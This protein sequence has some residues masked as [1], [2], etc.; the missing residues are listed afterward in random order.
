[1]V[2]EREVVAGDHVDTGVLLELPVVSTEV[3]AD[4]L[5]LLGSDLAAPVALG[6]LLQ[7]TLGANTGKT[8]DSRH[9]H[10]C[11]SSDDS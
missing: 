3:L 9:H 1:V 7:L 5:E 10:Y 4:L 6:G 2:V 11:I 8:Q